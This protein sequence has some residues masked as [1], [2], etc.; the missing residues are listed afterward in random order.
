MFTNAEGLEVE[1]LLGARVAGATPATG[2]MI[3]RVGK[4]DLSD[5]R[6]VIAKRYSDLAAAGT[7]S[8]GV[9]RAKLEQSVLA[10]L[11]SSFDPDFSRVKVPRPLGVLEVH[12][13][14]VWGFQSVIPH[15]HALEEYLLAEG[16][17][18]REQL[19]ELG[20]LLGGWMATLH[21]GG[22]ASLKES[23]RIRNHGVQEVRKVVQYDD[24]ASVLRGLR[25]SLGTK[26]S[27]ALRS[28]RSLMETV[29]GHFLSS[30]FCLTMGDAWPRSILVTGEDSLGVIDWEFAH[31]GSHAQDVSHLLSHLWMIRAV[32]DRP[33]VSEKSEAVLS[34]AESFVKGYNVLLGR[35][36]GEE[37]E[38]SSRFA[39]ES[40][41]LYLHA[42]A[43]LTMRL[44]GPYS[45]DYLLADAPKAVRLSAL[46][47]VELLLEAG[48]QLMA[49]GHQEFSIT[50]FFRMM[51]A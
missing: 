21:T 25:E 1:A 27:V 7:S 14:S 47:K 20:E 10:L 39:S 19:F 51:F 11:T 29:G 8:L 35:R 26:G 49:K 12:S 38:I 4:L 5:G 45:K 31:F 3:N 30:G 24:A 6:E 32:A 23:E 48:S 50:P 36:L 9:D 15:T 22:Y 28:V 43:E 34:F 18:C 17:A 33:E 2:G 37:G 42:A 16:G 46:E 41:Y 13:G 40:A 44:A